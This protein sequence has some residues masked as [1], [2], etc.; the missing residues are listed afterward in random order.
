VQEGGG[1]R[2]SGPAVAPPKLPEPD[3]PEFKPAFVSA[4]AR[5]APNGEFW[6]QRSQPAG[7]GAL[8]DGFDG[9]GRL[10]QQ[11]RLAK[12]TRLVGFG[13]TSVYVARTDN[14]DELQYLQRFRRP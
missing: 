5:V 4:G 2:G 11:V 14:D 1:G 9:Q 13:S 3:W 8:Y 6:V 10:K 7:A 12:D